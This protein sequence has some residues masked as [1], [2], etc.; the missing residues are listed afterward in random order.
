M[1]YKF[2]PLAINE[3]EDVVNYYSNVDISLGNEFLEE[4]IQLSIEY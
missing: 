2:N 4:F 1:N 3:L